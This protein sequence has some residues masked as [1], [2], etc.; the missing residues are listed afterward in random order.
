MGW[1]V[2]PLPQGPP[3]ETRR[4]VGSCRQRQTEVRTGVTLGSS[5]RVGVFPRSRCQPQTAQEG[6]RK[7]QRP[8]GKPKDTLT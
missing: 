5:P 3:P 2:L 7:Q 8:V 6:L 4:S 1:A